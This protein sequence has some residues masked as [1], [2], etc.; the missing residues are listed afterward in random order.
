MN[1]LWNTQMHWLTLV[2]IYLESI[3]LFIQV[4]DLLRYPAERKQ[5]WY[6]ILLCLLIGFNLAVG[7][8]PD[9]SSVFVL[10]S[11]VYAG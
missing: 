10:K 4:N 2:L 3:F 1:T 6:L 5:F 7:L 8:Y 11:T 9:T